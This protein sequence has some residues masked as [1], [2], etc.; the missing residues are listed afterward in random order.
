MKT[1]DFSH[2]IE[3]YL[4]G[5]MGEEEKGWFEKELEGNTKLSAEVELRRKT[6]LILK[7]QDIMNLRNKLSSIEKQRKEVKIPAATASRAGYIKYAAVLTALIVIGSIFI[8]KDRHMANDELVSK[9][10]RGYE[11]PA[12]QRSATTTLNA[13]FT[14]ALEFYNTDDFA[15][16]ARFFSKV[17]ESDP[18]D[19]QSVLLY[20]VSNFEDKKYPEAKKSFV[21]VI[22]DNNNLFIE[23][24][25]WYLAMCYIKTDENEKARGQLQLIANEGGLYAKNARKIMKSLK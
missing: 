18:K 1:I 15:N 22:D 8:F 3:R 5:E 20:G 7:Q 9:Y 10:Y 12:V 2:F 23:T 4:A 24:A 11:P 19:M 6:D 14:L 17:I 16:A 13:N 25:Q 21:S